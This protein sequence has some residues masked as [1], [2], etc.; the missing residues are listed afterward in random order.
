MLSGKCMTIISKLWSWFNTV[1]WLRQVCWNTHQ[2]PIHLELNSILIT[3]FLLDH[4]CHIPQCILFGDQH[5]GTFTF[6][7]AHLITESKYPYIGLKFRCIIGYVQK[8]Y[9]AF[10]VE[11]A[12][13][14]ASQ[15]CCLMLKNTYFEHEQVFL[16]KKYVKVK[17]TY[18]FTYEVQLPDKF[19][20]NRNNFKLS[21]KGLRVNKMKHFQIL[22]PTNKNNNKTQTHILQLLNWRTDEK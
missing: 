12:W 9:W 7:A 13:E 19:R 14:M 18:E 22:S 1:K 15:V 20:I 5:T 10:H 16:K 6:Q 11:I 17:K 4:L 21:Y 2:W 8:A 3:E